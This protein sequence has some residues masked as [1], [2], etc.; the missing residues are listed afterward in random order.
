MQIKYEEELLKSVFFVLF[1][2]VLD[3]FLSLS[4]SLISKWNE[5]KKKILKRPEPK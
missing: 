4:L 1:W 5:M 2:Y 3:V